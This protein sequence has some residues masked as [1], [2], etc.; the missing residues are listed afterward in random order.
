MS[1]QDHASDS[2]GVLLG[3]LADDFFVGPQAFFDDKLVQVVAEELFLF[4]I[5]G[6]LVIL[7]QRQS[8]EDLRGRRGRR[9]S[10]RQWRLALINKL[11]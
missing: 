3:I 5:S 1:F 9:N 6:Q 8:V 10:Y 11:L 7:I 2:A 4:L